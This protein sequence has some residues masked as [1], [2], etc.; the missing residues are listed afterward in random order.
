[1]SF[2]PDDYPNSAVVL[3]VALLA[4]GRGLLRHVDDEEPV[5]E[6]A[7]ARAMTVGDG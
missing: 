4:S 3:A 6:R 1:M 5:T 7:H 2:L